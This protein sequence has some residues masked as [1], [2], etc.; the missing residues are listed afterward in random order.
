MK[1]ARCFIAAAALSFSFLGGVH[2]SW[3]ERDGL[4]VHQGFNSPSFVEEAPAR[5]WWFDNFRRK[6]L[7]KT[8]GAESER[9]QKRAV[10]SVDVEP[11]P[12]IEKISVYEP[13]RLVALSAAAFSEP[14][15][16]DPLAAAIY[17]ELLDPQSAIRITPAQEAVILAL[18]KTNGFKPLWTT[19]GGL[20][21]RGKEVLGFLASAAEDGMEPEDYLPPA[22][23]SFSDPVEGA[24]LAQL[25]RVDLGL[26]A[27]ALRYARDASGGRLI[28]GRLTSYNDITPEPVDLKTA[29]KVL[30]W[31]PF[32][33]A[34]LRDLQP[35]HPAYAA[36]R[37]ALADM[38]KELA[39]GDETDAIPSGKRIKPG[40]SD[41]RVP[42]ARK[43]LARLGY[44]DE[45]GSG[46][47]EKLDSGLSAAL[48]SFQKA[49][50]IKASGSLDAATVA[51]LNERSPKR[52][53]EK[54]VY[55]MERLRW[56]PKALGARHVFVNQAAFEL[57]VID[58]GAETW[59]TRII[60]GKPDTQTFAFHDEIE[61]VVFNP[62]WGVPQSIIKNEMLPMLRK[63]PSYLDRLGYRVINQSGDIVRSSS[64]NWWGV[65]GKVI[66]FAIQQPPSDDNALGEIKFL[67]PNKHDIYM[68]DTPTKPLF[69]KAMRAY[70]H[71]CVRVQ[72]PRRFGEILLGWSAEEIA[73]KIDSGRSETVKLPHKV[74]VHLTYFTAWPEEDGKI[75][76]YS[77]VYGRDQ[78][79]ER[80]FAGIELASR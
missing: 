45:S 18:Y 28:P 38:R 11:P 19:A 69:A 59:R 79:M 15:P 67:F 57:R 34:Y 80:A 25:A 50:S 46:E 6:R 77:D 30:A 20:S 27:V 73:A 39:H 72:D 54:I 23:Q 52:D 53:L 33:V 55:N 44:V 48:K 63:D 66:P 35:H 51:A 62:S 3:A 1:A 16:S 31:S 56:L 64:I 7:R 24:D 26:S 41:A 5:S 37:K 60:V 14:A 74:P 65:G 2:W 42:L 36:L 76:F 9:P 70:S 22:L 75:A 68:H 47:D 4:F 43:A 12:P 29:M 32:P 10:Q 58:R 61:M 71:G 8:S 78:R 49:N 17:T 13:E 40:Q 21:P